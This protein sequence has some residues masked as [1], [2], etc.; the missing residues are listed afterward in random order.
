MYGE[1]ITVGVMLVYTC[2]LPTDHHATK[3]RLAKANLVR[4]AEVGAPDCDDIKA[5]DNITQ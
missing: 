4:W 1:W 2:C 5:L 3:L